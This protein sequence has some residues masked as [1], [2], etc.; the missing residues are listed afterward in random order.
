M[1]EAGEAFKLWDVFFGLNLL[2]AGPF[3]ATQTSMLLPQLL[4]YSLTETIQ[5]EPNQQLFDAL[6]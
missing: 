5:R 3:T 1:A 2:S 4:Q 6:C